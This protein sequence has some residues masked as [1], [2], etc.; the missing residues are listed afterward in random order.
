M[1]GFVCALAL[2]TGIIGSTAAQSTAFVIQGGPTVGRQRWDNNFDNQLLFKYHGA[3]AIESYENENNRNTLYL[4][5]GY[6]VK[7]SANRFTYTTIGQGINRFTVEFRFTNLSLILGA[8]QKIPL[9]SGPNRLV[10]FGGIRGDYTV[11]TNLK[12]LA[13]GNIF[14]QSIYPQ[15]GFVKKFMFGLTLGTGI[16]LPFSE[17]VGGQIT[18]SIHPDLTNQYNQPPIPN[19]INPNSP[20]QTYTIPERRIRNLTLELSFGVRLL[21]KVVYV[22]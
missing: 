5:M 10:Y 18:L 14:L 17:L 22:D 20:G 7:G 3:L 4:Q 16:E 12:E 11:G 21:K 9:G 19:V 15:E 8:K 6:H 2:T 13:Q 1:K